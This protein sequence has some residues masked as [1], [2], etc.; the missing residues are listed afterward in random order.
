[1]QKLEGCNAMICGRNYHGGDQ[2]DGCGAKFTWTSATLYQPRVTRRELPKLDEEKKMSNSATEVRHLFMS[3]ASCGVP[4]IKGPR[5]KCLHCESLSLCAACDRKCAATGEIRCSGASNHRPDHV[6]QILVAPESDYNDDIPI[7]TQVRLWGLQG[8]NTNLNGIVGTVA[9]YFPA[10]TFLRGPFIAKASFEVRIPPEV[11]GNELRIFSAA[12]VQLAEEDHG[13]LSDLVQAMLAQ[14]EARRIRHNLPRGSLVQLV[15]P[16]LEAIEGQ[17]Q[18]HQGELARIDCSITQGGE[19]RYKVRLLPPQ[20]NRNCATESESLVASLF[21]RTGASSL[22]SPPRREQQDP[23]TQEDLEPRN[24]ASIYA[25]RDITVAAKFVQHILEDPN[26]LQEAS[27]R[28]KEYAEAA[29]AAGDDVDV[30]CSFCH[31]PIY[32]A[33]VWDGSKPYHFGCR[34]GA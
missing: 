2:Q 20:R 30:D 14:Q 4:N 29:K 12:C 24:E 21:K 17:P 25:Q 22:F 6:F 23:E 15:G 31:Q 26:S 16:A 13:K 18:F 33:V 7:G 28:A 3:C 10:R 19:N 8:E 27:A 34:K 5:F 9:R 1:V 11:Q 32:G